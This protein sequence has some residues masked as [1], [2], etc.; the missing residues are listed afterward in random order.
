MFNDLNA[1]R[2]NPRTYRKRIVSV[3]TWREWKRETGRKDSWKVFKS[4]WELIA[5][6]NVEIVLEERDGIRMA[7]NLGD[8]YAGYVK[9]A[10]RKR[11]LDYKTSITLGVPFKHENW[12]SNN[13]KI[14]IIYGTSRR[15]YIYKMKFLWGFLAHRDFDRA[16]AA[17][18]KN[19]PE[20]YKNTQEKRFELTDLTSNPDKIKRMLKKRRI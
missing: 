6:K 19:N 2:F 4:T 10:S 7:E 13:K 12:H 3:Q 1:P 9:V 16:V 11:D 15:K 17:S 20:I 14:K 8:V 5:A 18:V